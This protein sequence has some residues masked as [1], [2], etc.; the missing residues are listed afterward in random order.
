[1]G[2]DD[3]YAKLWKELLRSQE[4]FMNYSICVSYQMQYE[5][6]KAKQ[7]GS[8]TSKKRFIVS[9]KPAKKS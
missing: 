8:V 4:F 3:K 7:Q 5:D 9:S 1:M 6:L 2:L